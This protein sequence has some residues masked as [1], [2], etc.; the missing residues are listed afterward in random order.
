MYTEK[1][2]DYYEEKLFQQSRII[3]CINTG[4][5]D[6]FIISAPNL[7]INLSIYH[8]YFYK[9][10]KNRFVEYY[11]MAFCYPK[12]YKKLFELNKTRTFLLYC[13]LFLLAKD[14]SY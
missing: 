7:L 14:H 13:R 11:R 10:Q 3:G 5:N 1:N 9:K 2:S 8:E 4:I 12:K 6:K